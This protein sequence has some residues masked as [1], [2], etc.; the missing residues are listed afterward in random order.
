MNPMK[1]NESSDKF[2]LSIN[3]TPNHEKKQNAR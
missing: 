3:Y 2:I 1:T